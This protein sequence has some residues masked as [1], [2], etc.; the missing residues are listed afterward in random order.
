M[1]LCLSLP[2]QAQLKIPGTKDFSSDMKQ[3]I[4]DYPHNFE[5]M[6]GNIVQELPQQT[7]Y[8]SKFKVEGTESITISRYS[9]N[10]KQVF[11]WQALMLTTEDFETAKAR[12]KTLYAR[13]NNM[14]VKMDYGVT[15]YLK[16]VYIEPIEERGFTSCLFRFELP[17]RITKKM[18]LELT[19]QFEFPEWKIKLMIYERDREDNE[20]GEIIE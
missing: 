10:Q 1:A 4:R 20:Q 14:A 15:F 2:S 16:G 9:A 17:D 18:I 5:S 3:V 19:M 12:F 7:D 8:E 13:F 6:L 11:S